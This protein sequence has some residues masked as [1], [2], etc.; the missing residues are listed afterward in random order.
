MDL[1]TH[2]ISAEL[3]VGCTGQ[4]RTRRMEVWGGARDGA[5]R[6][7][8][9]ALRCRGVSEDDVVSSEFVG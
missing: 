4:K 5:S 9:A 1:R 6:R 2:L 3:M 7:V 8:W